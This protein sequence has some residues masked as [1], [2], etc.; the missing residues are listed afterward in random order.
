MIRRDNDA[1]GGVGVDAPHRRMVISAMMRLIHAHTA[2]HIG[3]VRELLEEYA[4]SLDTDLCFQNFEREL[5]ELPGDYVPPDGRL[6]MAVDGNDGAG[7]GA[8]RKLDGLTCEMKRLYVR[9]AFRG[10]GVGK[11]L[12]DAI[13]SEARAAGYERV[14]LDTLPEMK[15]AIALYRS[16]GFHPTGAYRYN[17]VPGA[18][19]LELSLKA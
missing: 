18:L 12:V 4:A 9:P 13:L 10:N 19:F 14:C 2:E 7:C 15:E 5:A 3:R 16:L 11:S 8:L 1:A 17:P 6:L